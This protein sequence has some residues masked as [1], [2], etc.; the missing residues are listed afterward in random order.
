M[1][2]TGERLT[3]L[4]WWKAGP[5]RFRRGKS[6]ITNTDSGGLP[7]CWQNAGIPRLWCYSPMNCHRCFAGRGRCGS[8]DS[9]RS[10]SCEADDDKEP[11][12]FARVPLDDNASARREKSAWRPSR[13]CGPYRR[14][15]QSPAC[16]PRSFKPN[17][18]SANPGGAA[19]R[20]YSDD[21][22]AIQELFGSSHRSS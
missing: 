22:N 14:K 6:R 2:S 12:R 8:P 16:C 1:D 4:R 15:A 9:R 5:P 10:R 7:R 19:L 11:A 21:L 3:A 20:K 17:S 13:S 18:S